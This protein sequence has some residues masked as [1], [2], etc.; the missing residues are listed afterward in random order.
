[1]RQPTSETLYTLS[2]GTDQEPYVNSLGNP[3]IQINSPDVC[4]ECGETSLITDINTGELVCP[5]CGIVLSTIH[6]DPSPEWRAFDPDQVEERSRAGSPT[7][8]TIKDKGLS[9]RISRKNRDASGRVLDPDQ[10]AMLRRLRKLN[11]RS[12][13]RAQRHLDKALDEITKIGGKLNLP[14]NV[15]ETASLIY[16][17]AMKRGLALRLNPKTAA[18][19]IYI[20]CRQCGCMRTIRDV[21]EASKVPEKTVAKTYR[22]LLKF[23][24]AHMPKTNTERILGKLVCSLELTGETEYLARSILKPVEATRL[25]IGRAPS[26]IAA[27]CIYMSCLLL[28][29]DVTPEQIAA[30]AEISPVTIRK[31]FKEFTKRLMVKISL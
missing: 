18:A 10:K 16:R 1:M 6:L 4:A 25:T 27:A 5:S 28:S 3:I 31:R 26:G 23:T 19:F 29:E 12:H 13:S 30:R 11:R 24:G 2:T 22:S 7:T 20:A 21:A 14:E 17:Y 9:T 8:L 15:L